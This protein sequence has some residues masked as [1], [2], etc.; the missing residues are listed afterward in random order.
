[1]WVVL[2]APALHR[3]KGARAGF[4]TC[5]KANPP[6]KIPPCSIPLRPLKILINQLSLRAKLRYQ[7]P[8][9]LSPRSSRS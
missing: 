8:P 3:M 4:Y 6:S 9:H 2:K 7:V 1:M 5:L